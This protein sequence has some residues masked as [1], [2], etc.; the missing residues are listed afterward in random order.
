MSKIVQEIGVDRF[1]PYVRFVNR[2]NNA[3]SGSHIIPWRILYDFEMIFVTKGSLRVLTE[4]SSYLIKEGCLHIMPPFVRHRRIVPDGV[5]TNYFSVHLDFMFDESSS[6]FSAAEIYQAP[7]DN[8]LNTVP[9]NEILIEGRKNYKLEI[10]DLVESYEVRNKA[11]FIELFNKMFEAY[12]VG[13]PSSFLKTKAY[14]TLIIAE[15]IED[16]QLQCERITDGADYVSQFVDYAMNHYSD[17]IDL[18]EIVKEFNI[19]PSRFRAVFKKQMNRTPWEY[20]I[21]CRIEQAKKLFIT[22]K[23]NMSEVSYMVGYDDIHYFSRLF[24]KKVGLAPTEFLKNRQ[25]GK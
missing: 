8:K 5:I 25:E 4:R 17:G 15:F 10:V 11:R 9:D 22:G 18:G 2:L 21:D 12:Q 6:D 24:K 7:C 23:Y 16:L 13:E 20:V 3:E 14:M 1:N 19:S